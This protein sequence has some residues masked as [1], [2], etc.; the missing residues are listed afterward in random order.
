MFIFISHLTVLARTSVRHEAF[1]VMMDSRREVARSLVLTDRVLRE[2]FTP[3]EADSI[4]PCI[5]AALHVLQ[6]GAST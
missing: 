2:R 5:A 6:N 1:E 4:T 3:G